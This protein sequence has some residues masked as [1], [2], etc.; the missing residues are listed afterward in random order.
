MVATVSTVTASESSPWKPAQGPSISGPAPGSTG[1]LC[2]LACVVRGTSSPG[3][4]SSGARCPWHFG[5]R[6]G[7]SQREGLAGPGVLRPAQPMA[8]RGTVCLWARRHAARTHLPELGCSG[9]R[10]G[11]FRLG[12]DSP[13]STQA[14]RGRAWSRLSDRV[15]SSRRSPVPG[16]PFRKPRGHAQRTDSVPGPRWPLECLLRILCDR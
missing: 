2:P 16:L 9:P 10:A 11:V 8:T 4:A 12:G 3:L 13:T 14:F 15:P 5:Y 1:G 7:F 6:V